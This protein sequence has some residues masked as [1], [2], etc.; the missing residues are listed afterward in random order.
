MTALL[1]E[2][3]RLT[4]E[5]ERFSKMLHEERQK[6]SGAMGAAMDNVKLKKQIEIIQHIARGDA[7]A[8]ILAVLDPVVYAFNLDIRFDDAT[9]KAHEAE[10]LRQVVKRVDECLASLRIKKADSANAALSKPST[11]AER[12]ANKKK[13]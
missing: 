4:E 10:V 3:K 12:S 6:V 13:S 1:N 11:D 7:Q 5:N 9:A 8:A 2:V